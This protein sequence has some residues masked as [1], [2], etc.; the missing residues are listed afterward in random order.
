MDPV[1]KS[2]LTTPESVAFEKITEHMVQ[3]FIRKNHDYGNSFFEDLEDENDLGPARYAIGNKWRRFKQ[4]SMNKDA[5]VDESI[6]DTLLDMANYCVM[7]LMWLQ[8]RKHE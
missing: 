1:V 3:T 8:D 7:T 2:I 6:E 4:L 5:Q